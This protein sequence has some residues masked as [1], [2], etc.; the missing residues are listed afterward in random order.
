MLGRASPVNFPH[1]NLSTPEGEGILSPVGKQGLSPAV[2][3][4]DALETAPGPHPSHTGPH[5]GPR[6]T[7]LGSKRWNSV[8]GGR[9]GSPKCQM[10]GGPEPGLLL[11]GLGDQIDGKKEEVRNR[12]KVVASWLSPGVRPGMVPLIPPSQEPHSCTSCQALL[13]SLCQRL[14]PQGGDA[15]RR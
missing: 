5:P 3:L 2:Q 14:S 6:P 4:G 12:G 1:T 7:P 15:W 10:A 11:L 8:P 13:C 9:Q